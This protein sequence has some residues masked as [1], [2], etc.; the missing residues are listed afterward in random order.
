M[1]T[2]YII[3]AIFTFF[4]PSFLAAE[5]LQISLLFRILKFKKKV[6]PEKENAGTQDQERKGETR[7]R[8]ECV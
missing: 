4:F 8:R 6:S 1:R 7:E 5:N 3:L 2:K